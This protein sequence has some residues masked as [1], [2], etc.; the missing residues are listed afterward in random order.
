MGP[1]PVATVACVVE[2]WIREVQRGNP[3]LAMLRECITAPQVNQH[4]A[5]AGNS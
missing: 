4:G 3:A 2:I 1:Q 5:D